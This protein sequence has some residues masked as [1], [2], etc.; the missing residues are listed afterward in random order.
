MVTAIFLVFGHISSLHFYC[1]NVPY[2]VR[3]KEPSWCQFHAGVDRDRKL[4]PVSPDVAGVVTGYFNSVVNKADI[5]KRMQRG[6]T[7]KDLTANICTDMLVRLPNIVLDNTMIEVYDFSSSSE[8][9]MILD[10][11]VDQ[12]AKDLMCMDTEKM[13]EFEGILGRLPADNDFPECG[14]HLVGDKRKFVHNEALRLFQAEEGNMMEENT[15]LLQYDHLP[16]L[17]TSSV[18]PLNLLANALPKDRNSPFRVA[19]V[20]ALQHFNEALGS[21]GNAKV[22]QQQKIQ[23]CAEYLKSLLDVTPGRYIAFGAVTNFHECFFVALRAI[24]EVRGSHH[25]RKYHPYYSS[26]IIGKEKVARELASFC[27]TDPLAMGLNPVFFRSPHLTVDSNLGRGSTGVVMQCRWQRDTIALKVS[28]NKNAL[29]LERVILRYLETKGISYV[30]KIHKEAQ[31]DLF[32]R[33]NES[34]TAFFPV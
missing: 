17:P 24:D 13:F 3:D 11:S 2:P 20:V 8:K 32:P 33:Y 26:L 10:F 15:A 1:M 7:R 31:V 34:C 29:E 22:P 9:G 30:P 23:E 21:P 12:V 18:Q 25:L 27:A 4:G 14:V 5:M 19:F 6:Q 16:F 28:I